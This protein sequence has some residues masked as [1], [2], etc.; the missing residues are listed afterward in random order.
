MRDIVQ[1]RLSAAKRP[2][3][4]KLDPLPSPPPLALD[5]EDDRASQPE[6]GMMA[7]DEGIS[8]SETESEEEPKEEEQ[9]QQI[10]ETPYVANENEVLGT[11]SITSFF[12]CNFFLGLLG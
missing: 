4:A 12:F 11:V 10:R 1:L 2:A 8:P 3:V 7:A 9:D 6:N 5:L